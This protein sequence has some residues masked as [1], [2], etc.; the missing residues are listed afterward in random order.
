MSHLA[1]VPHPSSVAGDPDM[2]PPDPS[3]RK[4]STLS[5]VPATLLPTNS[6]PLVLIMMSDLSKGDVRIVFVFPTD[7]L[8]PVPKVSLPRKNGFTVWSVLGTCSRLLEVASK[9][10]S[11]FVDFVKLIGK[12]NLAVPGGPST[13]SVPVLEVEVKSGS[14]LSGSWKESFCP[15]VWQCA[16]WYAPALEIFAAGHCRQVEFEFAPWAVL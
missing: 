9:S 12:L 2:G 15:G 13:S 11:W 16:K 14:K 5:G 10:S 7:G 8:M 4:Y 3:S 6:L 1:L